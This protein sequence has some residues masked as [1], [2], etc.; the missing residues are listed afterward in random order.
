MSNNAKVVAI[1]PARL[2][3]TRLPRKV[4]LDETG[5]PLI[6][7]VY[8]S[9]AKTQGLSEIIIATDAQEVFDACVAFGARAIMTSEACQSGSDRV[10]EAAKEVPDAD[11]I[12]NVQGD[13]PEMDPSVLERLAAAMLEEGPEMGTVVVPWPSDIALSNEGCVKCVVDQKGYALYF[14]RAA[15]P[16]DQTK[17]SPNYLRHIGIYAYRPDFL[18]SFTQWAPTPLESA[19]SL[20]QLRALE[21]GA[22]IRVIESTYSGLEVN[23]PEDYARFVADYGAKA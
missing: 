5:K 20:E 8:E 13:E 16:F 18:Q 6:Q 4:L 9:V 19:E 23:T 11:L 17:D 22:R 1:I 21:H 12:I 2:G 3:S 10:A 7:H 14:S 15:I